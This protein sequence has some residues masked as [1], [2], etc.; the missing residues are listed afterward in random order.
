MKSIQCLP[1]LA[2]TGALLANALAPQVACAQGFAAAYS[3]PSTGPVPFL[4]AASSG[5]YSVTP[6]GALWRVLPSVSGDPLIEVLLPPG[7]SGHP[8]LAERFK[9]QFPLNIGKIPVQRRA[10]VLGFH[11]F[12]VSEQALFNPNT[13]LPMICQQRGWLL[14][15]PFGLVDTNFANEPSQRA[16]EAVLAFVDKYFDWNAERIYAVGFSMGGLNAL[17]FG[18]RHQDPGSYRL[19]GLVSHVGT[20]DPIYA[21]NTG[22]LNLQLIMQNPLVFG[23]SPTSVP[24]NYERVTAGR[25]NSGNALDVSLAPSTNLLDTRVY[26]SINQND[27]ETGLK[28]QNDALASYL[29][30]QGLDLLVNKYSGPALH[31]W[32]TL[33][34]V[35]ACNWLESGVAPGAAPI[36]GPPVE[37]FA[38]R[39]ARY[40]FTEVRGLS[41]SRVARYNIVLG[42]AG[43]NSFGVLGTR[44]LLE[45]AIDVTQLGLQTGQTLAFTTWST[46]GTA[47]T[48]VIEQFPQSPN[49]IQVNGLAPA[50][51]S[52]DPQSKELSIRPTNNGSFVTVVIAP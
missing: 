13:K 3:Q 20:V 14:L 31:S 41:P 11:H 40:R 24:F 2:L 45:L 18:L 46:D 33:D 49:S 36:N 19:A 23:G 4:Q 22:P 9:L 6:E 16:L 52:Y 32:S 12:G 42:G 48:F 44:N 51:W 10:M 7:V 25:I 38:D 5:A 26:L 1:A 21:Y 30:S 39:P 50:A 15:A 47:P 37:I 35:T 17:S 43:S 8:T 27:P 28:L 29:S 34:D